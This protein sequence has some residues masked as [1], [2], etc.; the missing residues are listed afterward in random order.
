[1]ILSAIPTKEERK[2]ITSGAIFA[3]SKEKIKRKLDSLPKG[4]YDIGKTAQKLVKWTKELDTT[5]YVTANCILPSVSHLSGYAEALDVVGYSYRRVLYDY[6]H[7]NYPNKPIMGTE[8]LVQWHEWKAVEERPFISGTFLWTGIDYMGESNNKWPRKATAS[9][10][11]DIAGFEKPSYHMMKTLW[12][13]EPHIYVATQTIAKSIFKEDTQTGKVVE[14]KKGKWKK[15]L[16]VWHN[17]NEHWN[18]SFNEKIVV[19]AYS[20]FEEIELCLNGKSF[21]TKKLEN[22]EDRIYKWV[23]PFQEGE[24]K[25]IG[26]NGG[27]VQE[28]KVLNTVGKVTQVSLTTDKKTIR[29]DG[30]RVAH[31]VAQLKDTKGNPIKNEAEEIVFSVEGDVQ[32]LGVDNGSAYSVQDYKS[33]TVTT[34]KGKCLLIIQSKRKNT[35][36]LI[37]ASAK[38]FKSKALK[39]VVK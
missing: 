37:T 33:N 5:R 20:N 4:K 29:A 28:I 26:K 15:A 17:V 1:M 36:A 19:E 2:E 11:L 14:K 25:L 32:V 39:I 12:N 21:Q 10:M 27:E 38:E 31:I 6:G 13:K 9:G 8:N 3:F 34:N 7:K 22:F 16:W 35:E 18:Y 30:Y 23:V 24:L